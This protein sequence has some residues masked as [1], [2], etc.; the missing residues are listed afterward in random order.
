MFTRTFKRWIVSGVKGPY[1]RVHTTDKIRLRPAA[2]YKW[3]LKKP[4][5]GLDSN[6][7]GVL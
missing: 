1:Q 3:F 6:E 7:T 2:F 4:V 5:G